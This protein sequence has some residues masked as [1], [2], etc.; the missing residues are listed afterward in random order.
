MFYKTVPL[1]HG[2]RFFR[3]ISN[4]FI[5]CL[6]AP[7]VKARPTP[8]RFLIPASLDCLPFRT[9]FHRL[10]NTLPRQRA[11]LSLWLR[12]FCLAAEASMDVV[13]AGVVT[14]EA[15][16]ALPGSSKDLSL[17]VGVSSVNPSLLLRFWWYNLPEAVSV[18]SSSF[19]D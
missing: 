5:R 7:V 13:A 10:R 3:L 17:G 4:L 8:L 1:D 6:A 15:S 19:E 2:I 16:E 9:T 11:D 18:F 14:M 12:A